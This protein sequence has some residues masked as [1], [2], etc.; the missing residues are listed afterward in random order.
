MIEIDKDK[1]IQVYG[2]DHKQGI[3][4]P[5]K[6]LN[7]VIGYTFTIAELAELS[8]EEMLQRAV[9]NA[10]IRNPNYYDDDIT[11]TFLYWHDS[12]LFDIGS[13]EWGAES[14][15]KKLWLSHFFYTRMMKYKDVISE[16]IFFKTAK[17]CVI[18]T[19]R[20]VI[21]KIIEHIKQKESIEEKQNAH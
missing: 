7:S 20:P 9:E 19:S 5:E 21:K 2:G 6:M 12:Y 10:Y 13:F 3:I 17:I 11:T 1:E 16:P 8:Y 4:V 18:K 15:D 14:G